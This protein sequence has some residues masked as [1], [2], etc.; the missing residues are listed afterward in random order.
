V[1][2]YAAVDLMGG[3][4]VQLVGGRAEDTRI[5]L[6]DPAAVARDWV[7]RGFGALHVVDL[8]AALEQ[9]H[10]RAAIAALL[11]AV[12]VPVQVGGGVR[13]EAAADALFE[14]GAARVVVGTR[15]VRD[16]AWLEE[17]VARHPARVV[18]AADVRGAEVV[19]RGWTEGTGLDAAAF[20]GSLDDLELAGVLVTDVGREGRM[21]GADAARFALLAAATRHALLASGGVTDM[22]DLRRLAY[23]GAAGVVLGMALYTG[24]LDAAAV[25]REF[26]A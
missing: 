1:R 19:A 4:A 8:D 13:D 25:A 7:A 17:L 16:R 6:P 24:A 22:A 11:E 9:G 14:L 20:L 12:D 10:N 18:V 26:D 2:A 5:S 23:A 3:R 21:A 15:A